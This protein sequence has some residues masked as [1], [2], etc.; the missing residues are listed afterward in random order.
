MLT[1]TISE[2]TAVFKV[3]LDIFRNCTYNLFLYD[4]LRRF[5]NLIG[6]LILVHDHG[7][8]GMH[9]HLLLLWCRHCLLWYHS[10]L[11]RLSIQHLLVWYRWSVTCWCCHHNRLSHYLLWLS[12]DR[13][14]HQLFFIILSTLFH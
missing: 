9:H 5:I 4:Y 14:S 10:R 8:L 3:A 2:L 12:I 13:V 1:T 6:Y 7:L 11:T